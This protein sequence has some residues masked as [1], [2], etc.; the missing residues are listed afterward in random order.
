MTVFASP[1]CGC[2][3]T[4]VRHVEKAGFKVAVEH[5]AMADLY[6]R[7]QAAGFSPEHASCHTAVVDGYAIEGH[8]P[9]AD[10]RRLLEERPEAIGLSVPGMPADAPGMGTGSEPYEVLLV[11]ADGST[12][13]FARYPK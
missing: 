1:S 5:L 13:S 10:I 6:A 3:A 7:K 4:W 9:A 8:V 11:K 2:C 12:G